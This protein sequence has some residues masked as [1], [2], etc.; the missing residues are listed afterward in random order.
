M[1]KFR[2][3]RNILIISGMAL[4]IA[5]IMVIRANNEGARGIN[6]RHRD[7]VASTQHFQN[8]QESLWAARIFGTGA[9]A[10]LVFGVVRRRPR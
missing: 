1:S 8:R 9:L 7:P 3:S 2:P 5:L 6:N 10:T 4:A